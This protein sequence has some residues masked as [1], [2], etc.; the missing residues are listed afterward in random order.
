MKKILALFIL[1]FQFSALADVAVVTYNMAQLKKKG[2]DL[3]AC[4]S[5]RVAFQ[6][7]AIF[8]DPESPIFS[9]KNFVLLV[10]ESWTKKSFNALK[11]IALERG[12]SIFPDDH[13]FV[14]NSGQLIIS[15]LPPVEFKSMPFSH[16]KYASK[17]LIYARFY[18][19][20]GNTLGVI[21]V[22]T[23]YSEKRGFS[24]EHKLHFTELVEAV[25]KFKSQTSHFV[26]GGDF[27]AGP[28]M[29]YKNTEFNV[30]PWDELLVTPMKA[31]GMRLLESVGITWDETHNMLVR[32][33][34]LLLRLVNKYKNGYTGWDMTDSTLDHIFVE[35]DAEVLR[36]ELAF[37]KKV[38]LNCG[39]RDDKE[40][41]HLSDH[42]GVMAVIKTP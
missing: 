13:K 32:S 11:K 34:P 8:S 26:I 18:L 12:Y 3:V 40:G 22:H 39:R 10:Q 4:T 31:E 33:P 16:D 41:L 5:R 37:N 27:N 24:E 28:D 23:A 25:K 7:G 15:N 2:L 30:A 36:H 21:N 9:D 6:V 19:G 17:G 14:K 29:G 20:E 1:L 42:Y 35:E 38:H